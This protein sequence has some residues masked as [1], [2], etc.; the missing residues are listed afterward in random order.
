MEFKKEKIEG[1]ISIEP[2]I[3]G[4]ERGY[5]LETFNE[6]KYTEL[7]GSNFNFVQDN[8]SKSSKGVL[9]GLHFQ[10]P[11]FDQGKLVY[12][13]QGRAID[14]AVDIRKSSPTYGEHVKVFLDSRTKNQLWIPPG[15]AHGFCALEDETIF[16]YKCTNF[17]NPEN[18]RSILWNDTDLN[19]DWDI[20]N[21]IVSEKDKSALSFH[22]FLSPF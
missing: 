12:V 4:D 19:I 2:K 8:V 11:P 3:F 20:K 6:K 17:Y 9:R 5:F 7:I 13:L 15:F 1:I 16:C 14:I 22:S 21:P 18:E 10:I